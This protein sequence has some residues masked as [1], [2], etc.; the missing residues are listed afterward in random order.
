M[1]T[2]SELQARL[3]QLAQ[4]QQQLRDANNRDIQAANQLLGTI[5]QRRQQIDSITAELN[6]IRNEL[7]NLQ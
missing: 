5:N 2:V 6:R 1:A 3:Q 4:L 7:A